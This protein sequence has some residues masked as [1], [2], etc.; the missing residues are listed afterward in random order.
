V[1]QRAW[2]EITTLY[3]RL[4]DPTPWLNFIKTLLE[5]LQNLKTDTQLPL[6]FTDPKAIEEL[7]VH[8]YQHHIQL[9]LDPT[10]KAVWRGHQCI[11]LTEA[12]YALL[13]KLFQLKGIPNHEL[14]LGLAG[15]QA[16]LHTQI[17]R[18]RQE[19]EPFAGRYT[20]IKKGREGYWL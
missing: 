6:E 9:R 14:L 2:Q 13:E 10:Q 19:I 20:Y 16:N 7:L 11:S 5:H 4:P 17:K 18:L 8:Y 12:Q 15:T 3:P 1:W